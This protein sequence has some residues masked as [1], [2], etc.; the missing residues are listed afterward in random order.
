M[1]YRLQREIEK[2]KKSILTLGALVEERVHMAVQAINDRDEKL[3]RQVIDGDLQIDEMEVDLEEECLKLLALHQPVAID[4]RFIIAVL[5]I[6]NDLERIG[7]LAVNIGERA[8]FVSTRER[9]DIPFDF[10]TMSKIV[11]TM[12]K[13][14][15]DSLV[16]MDASL[17]KEVCKMDDDV[18]TI[19]RQMYDQV[20][21]GICNHPDRLELLTHLLSTSRHLERIG[22]L[23]TNIS[24]DVIYMIEGK[25]IRHKAED[26]RG[27]SDKKKK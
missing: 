11:K 6:N 24:E 2:L 14:S 15:L 22:D 21:E 4:L 7:D 17:A 27:T 1:P 16:N 18:D 26:Y 20:R 9:I 19:N 13:K 10:P 23:A 25:I 12:L 3:A 5:K 8:M